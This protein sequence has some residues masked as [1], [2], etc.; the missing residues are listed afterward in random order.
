MSPTLRARFIP[1]RHVVP[2]ALAT[3]LAVLVPLAGCRAGEADTAPPAR[4]T[5]APDEPEP[6]L[7]DGFSAEELDEDLWVRTILNDFE[8]E[9]V[10]IR[11]GRLRMMAS[12][13]HT[14]DTTVKYHGVRSREAIVDPA[15]GVEVAFELDWNDQS[16]GCYMTAGVC[17]SPVETD[18]PQHADDVLRFTYIGVPPGR[19]ARAWASVRTDGRS[20]TPVY[21]EGWP[22]ARTGRRIGKQRVVLRI[23]ENALSAEENGETLFE[24]TD[25]DL[26]L[27]PCYL[28]LQHSTHSNYGPREVFFDNVEVRQASK[29]AE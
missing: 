22:E 6:L 5:T 23:N 2:W 9:A 12:S 20:E 28:Y 7:A 11:D 1:A 17:L 16:N 27:G 3:L 10:D 15:A 8:T 13:V 21:T 25:V 29:N 24:A 19:H 18:D 4:A 14:D 26:D